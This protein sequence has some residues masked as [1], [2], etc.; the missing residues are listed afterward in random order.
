MKVICP[1]CKGETEIAVEPQIGQNVQCKYCERKFA[2]GVETPMPTRIAVPK[3][4]VSAANA[5]DQAVKVVCP[6]CHDKLGL[7]ARPAVGQSVKCQSCKRKFPYDQSL[8]FRDEI[9]PSDIEFSISET[10]KNGRQKSIYDGAADGAR[11]FL[12][13]LYYGKVF[14]HRIDLV[15]YWKLRDE[16][17]AELKE[18][19]IRYILRYESDR[20]VRDCLNKTL[21]RFAHKGAMPVSKPKIIKPVKPE[22]REAGEGKNVEEPAPLPEVPAPVQP[23]NVEGRGN[24]LLKVALVGFAAIVV[25]TSAATFLLL[26]RQEPLPEQSVVRESGMTRDAVLL[27]DKEL[28]SRL[29]EKVAE[30][31]RKLDDLQNACK[32]DFDD[33]EDR[34]NDVEDTAKRNL[35]VLKNEQDRVL[36]DKI[37]SLSEKVRE[38]SRGVGTGFSG[39]NNRPAIDT[40]VVKPVKHQVEDVPKENIAELQKQLEQNLKEIKR[41]RRSN[42]TCVLYPDSSKTIRNTSTKLCSA[43]MYSTSKQITY[44]RDLFY[45]GNCKKENTSRT[46]PCCSVSAKKGFAAWKKERDAVDVTMNINRQIEALTESNTDLKKRIKEAGGK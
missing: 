2:Y 8:D 12:G 35:D 29:L 32:R 28:E 3:R 37:S 13:L 14:E 27:A 9:A 20:D 4:P 15:K 38:L 44:V 5:Q 16:V 7:S 6:L 26:N 39:Q 23:S 21:A 24:G 34:I 18:S 17:L 40:E 33:L 42:P 19:D 41:L 1:Y 30:I 25:V 22:S 11:L 45:C 31:Q 43:N 10:I 36:S 46:S